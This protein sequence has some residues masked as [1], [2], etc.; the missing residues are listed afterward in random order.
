[1]KKILNPIMVCCIACLLILG[2]TAC[3]KKG[4][5]EKVDNIL[6]DVKEKIHDVTE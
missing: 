2:V 1:M 5:A 3:E 4:P 6:E